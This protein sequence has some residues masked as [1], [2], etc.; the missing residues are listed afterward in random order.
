M[1]LLHILPGFETGGTQLRLCSILNR[2]PFEA[3]HTIVALNGDFETAGRLDPGVT[4][5]LVSPPAHCGPLALRRLVRRLRPDLLLTYNW[6]AIEAVI[7]TFLLPPCPIV[8]CEGGVNADEAGR[9]KARRALTRR[10]VLNRIYQ[11]VVVSR[12]LE[13]VALQH[14]GLRPDKVR[15]IR[16]GVDTERFRPGG[17]RELR[18]ALGVPDGALVFGFTGR[19]VIEKS[20]EM[21]LDAFASLR[22]PEAR[23]MLVGEGPCRADLERRAGQGVIFTG[24][25]EDSAPY[26]AAMD[27]FVMSS[28]TEQTPNALLEAM[29]CGLPAVCTDVGD[30]SQILGERAVAPGDSARYRDALLRVAG[31][32]AL[33]AALGARNRQRA[34]DLFSVSRMVEEYAGLWL[35]ALGREPRPKGS[36][37]GK[38]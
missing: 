25:V 14:Y 16:T 23:L 4:R 18:R 37:F 30:T 10:L 34:V 31:D 11:T 15:Y 24:R 7:G 26:Y 35:E 17:S 38:K 9:V 28:V 6:G 13:R 1:H 19:L 3:R 5:Q 32:A 20:L 8:H 33:R 12:A 2:L 22:I 36:G 27:I 21:L 29:A